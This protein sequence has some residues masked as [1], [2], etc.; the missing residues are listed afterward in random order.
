MAAAE[1]FGLRVGL[2]AEVRADGGLGI[3][4]RQDGRAREVHATLRFDHQEMLQ[5]IRCGIR[6]GRIRVRR[7]AWRHLGGTSGR[8]A[9]VSG[10]VAGAV[11]GAVTYG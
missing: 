1:E 4:G 8:A 3:L 2:I 11:V 7:G 10:S 6:A 5:G 9:P